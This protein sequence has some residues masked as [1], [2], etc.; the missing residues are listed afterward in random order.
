MSTQNEDQDF[1]QADWFDP[2]PQPNTIPSG[3]DVSGFFRSLNLLPLKMRMPQ[4]KAEPITRASRAA[5]K[6]I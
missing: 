5:C 6:E 1:V 3:W 2:F 4:K